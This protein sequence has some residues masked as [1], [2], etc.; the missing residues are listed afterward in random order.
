MR[1]SDW[2]SDVCSS[3][4]ATIRGEATLDA[5][6]AANASVTATNVAT[7]LSR[8]VNADANGRYSLAGLPPGEYRVEMVADGRTDSPVVSVPVGQ[9]AT[10]DLATGGLD[11]T[12]NGEVGRPEERRVGK[13]CVRTFRYRWVTYH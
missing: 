9:V 8:S 13:E 1:I 7:G 12:A 3:D 2:S 10:L 11:Q 6:P 5:A 4:L